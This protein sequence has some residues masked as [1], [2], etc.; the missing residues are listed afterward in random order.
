[1]WQRWH[2]PKMTDSAR[3][4]LVTACVSGITVHPA[5]GKHWSP[6]RVDPQWLI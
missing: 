5:T 1:M 2:H 6:D 4:A 3:R